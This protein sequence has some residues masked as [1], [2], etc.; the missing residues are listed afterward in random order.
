M[1][2]Q[3]RSGVTNLVATF[4]SSTNSYPRSGVAGAPPFNPNFPTT[5]T[6]LVAWQDAAQI[7]GQA[8]NTP[9][10]SWP[11]QVN[12]PT[13]NLQQSGAF[14][15]TYYKTTA[16]KTVNG[17]PAVWWSG[18]Q[19]MFV[20]PTQSA[21]AQPF[22]QLLV[23]GV[24]AASGTQVFYD[25][26]SGTAALSLSLSGGNWVANAGSALTGPAADTSVHL[27]AVVANGASSQ[28]IVDGNATSGALGANGQI[29]LN[30]GQSSAGANRLTGVVCEIAL[31]S[32]VMS[33]ANLTAWHTYSKAK[34]ATA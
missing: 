6:G 26:D 13:W 7:T 11:T 19:G 27:F 5:V 24:T 22:T 29:Y 8:D 10:S 4:A 17:Q 15:P 25:S 3:R 23:A 21:Q 32:G 18:S 1:G 16:G 34:W 28:L 9:L 12:A 20:S 31:Y 14:R 33:G 30:L 2:G